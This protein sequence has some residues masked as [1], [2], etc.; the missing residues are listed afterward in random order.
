M[1]PAANDSQG[2]KIAT[3]LLAALALILGVATYFGFSG[4]AQNWEKFEQASK[5]ASS[6]KQAQSQLQ[7]QLNDL[8]ELAGY[9]NVDDASLK[10]KIADDQQKLTTAI[11]GL[12]AKVDEVYGQY[13][14]AAGATVN[15]Q[16]DAFADAT[17]TTAES[18]AQDPNKNLL[19]SLNRLV[20]LMGSQAQLFGAVAADYQA[21]RK[22]LEASNQVAKSKIDVEV[23]AKTKSD[24]DRLAELEKHE[25]DRKSLNSRLDE[26]QSK[27]QQLA[28]ENTSLRSLMA[29]NQEEATKKYNDLMAQFVVLRE[30]A[31]KSETQL[32]SPNGRILYADY[33]RGEVRTTLSRRQGASEQMIFT[34]FDRNAPGIPSD[35]PKG[36][37]QLIEVG[38]NGSIGRI[39][40]TEETINPIAVGDLLYSPAFGATRLFALIGK[41]DI[42]QDGRDDRE[43]LKRMIRSSGGDISYDLPPAGIGAESGE[44]TPLTS[45]YVIDDRQPIQAGAEVPTGAPPEDIEAFEKRKTEALKNA[46]Q[47][48]VRAISIERLLSMLNY[49]YDAPN[50]GRVEARNRQAYEQLVRPRGEQVP[51]TPPAATEG[52]DDAPGGFRSI[53]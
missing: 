33:N 19:S 13:K 21:T 16:G 30:Q 47:A 39:V 12:K 35:K 50:P 3:A 31:E 32:E 44:L 23:D 38:E 8:K 45:W 14:S 46:R 10:Q 4:A 7:N 18:F 34:V 22:E 11:S 42:D 9:G 28:A 15:P 41:I 24:E 52:A 49:R 53:R 5:D 25:V 2:L 29:Q 6:A 40:R 36:T 37:I 20:D 17:R 1:P 48:G 43:D 51:V 26:L 27:N